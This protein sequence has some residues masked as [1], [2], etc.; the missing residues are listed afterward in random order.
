MIM[1]I[2]LSLLFLSFALFISEDILLELGIPKAPELL[3]QLGLASIFLAFLILLITGLTFIIDQ[4]THSVLKY[5]SAH[6]R[7]H[8]RLLFIE[9][10]QVQLQQLFF[11]KA[12]QIN[13]FHQH[14]KK[15]LLNKDNK[16]QIKVL[17][18][19]IDKD[20]SKIKNHLPQDDYIEIY[21][22][23]K[24]FYSDQDINGLLKL[25]QTIASHALQN[26]SY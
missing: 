2:S 17:I 21:Q 15:H 8:R 5:F 3:T 26:E 6:E 13:Y 4:I 25:Q 19:I 22:A 12:Q 1:K 16:Q 18:S 10:K 7:I 24:K 14:H 20:L 11:F 23:R 9:A